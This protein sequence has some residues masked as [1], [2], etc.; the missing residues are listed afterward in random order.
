MAHAL[1]AYAA[2][3]GDIRR[4]VDATLRRLDAGIDALHSTLGRVIARAVESD[5]VLP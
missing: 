2:R 3:V 4:S 5:L 1:V